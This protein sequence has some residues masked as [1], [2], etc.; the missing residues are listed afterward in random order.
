MYISTNRHTEGIP[1]LPVVGDDSS[2]G[3]CEFIRIRTRKD[4]WNWMVGPLPNV[5]S[6]HMRYDSGGGVDDSH[7]RYYNIHL[8]HVVDHG[9]SRT[10]DLDGK[11]HRTRPF[12]C[13]ESRGSSRDAASDRSL[14]SRPKSAFRPSPTPSYLRRRTHRT[15]TN[16]CIAYSPP[17]C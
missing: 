5:S 8:S 17:S 10:F 13:H 12:T 15:Q 1:A 7:G 9:Y 4:R 3:V 16:R 2:G 14:A 6:E 11:S